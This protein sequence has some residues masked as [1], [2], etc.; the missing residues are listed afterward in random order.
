VNATLQNNMARLEGYLDVTKSEAN[1]YALM[2]TNLGFSAT[3]D[4]QM[5]N[6]IKVHALNKVNPENLMTGIPE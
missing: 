6:Y 3:D 2:K 5:L 4:S 1:A